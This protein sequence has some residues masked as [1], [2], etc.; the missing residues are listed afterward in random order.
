M[1]EQENKIFNTVY[2]NAILFL[3]RGIAEILEHNDKDDSPL[4]FE[5]GIVC[6]LFIQMSIELALKAFLVKEKGV[7]S[8]L[9]VR[10][11][12][13]TDMQ[14]LSEFEN[15][16]LHTKKYND[17]K[18][19]LI[20]NET[21]SWFNETSYSHLEQFQQ[22]RNKLVHLN[23]FLANA[24]LY[25]LKFELIYVIVHIIVPLLS[26]ISFEFETPSD[27]YKS[28]LNKDEFKKLISFP[29]Y[30]EEM[31]KLAKDFTG[32]NY[33]CPE[34]YQKTYSPENNL[35][36]CCNLNFENAA[37]YTSCIVCKK[38]NSVIFDPLNIALNNHIMNGLCLNCGIKLSVHKCPKC[39]TV[40]SFFDKKELKKCTPEKCFYD[41]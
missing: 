40:Y 34:C 3:K 15:N 9:E 30:I 35:C 38:K 13:K 31:E 37:E 8:I 6:T 22:F 5:T 36:Y 11:Q 20:N 24:D 23:L 27:F 19:I 25:D 4:K 12:R 18:Q 26:E 7:K 33:Y 41:E 14:I 32:F 39:E 1:N 17:L 2:N 28:H 10:Y 16:T 29:T 21:L